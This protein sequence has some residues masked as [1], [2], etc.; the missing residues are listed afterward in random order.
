MSHNI[1]MEK[2]GA[3][4]CIQKYSIQPQWE[5]STFPTLF[6]TQKELKASS[7][8]SDDDLPLWGKMTTRFLQAL[9][10]NI[11]GSIKVL[12]QC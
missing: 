12:L 11:S 4:M 6:F 2:H 5:F 8:S 7:N 10:P 3:K 9:Y 1:V